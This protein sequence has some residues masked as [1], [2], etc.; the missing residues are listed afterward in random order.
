[1]FTPLKF[2][3]I[4]K[5]K[6][7]FR[8]DSRRKTFEDRAGNEFARDTAK[9]SFLTLDKDD[10]RRQFA[11]E[12]ETVDLTLIPDRHDRMVHEKHRLDIAIHINGQAYYYL[13]GA[14]EY[15][16]AEK[17]QSNTAAFIRKRLGDYRK[18]QQFQA[19][20][21]AAS[22]DGKLELLRKQSYGLI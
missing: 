20:L 10:F 4:G 5:V 6:T 13:P 21:D 9:A 19:Q 16:D 15:Q 8:Q 3:A 12:A 22:D 11:E 17:L 14:E 7:D 18:E 1:M 2:A